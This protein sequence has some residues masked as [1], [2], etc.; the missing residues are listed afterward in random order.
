M[1]EN[2][3]GATVWYIY[4]H[5]LINDPKVCKYTIHGVLGIV[6]TN[7]P[8]LGRVVLH[9]AAACLRHPESCRTTVHAWFRRPCYGFKIPENWKTDPRE[10]RKA[11]R[12]SWSIK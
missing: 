2:K 7:P 4:L 8:I 6:H 5:F 11:L 1:L 12:T 10:G 3:N 9:G